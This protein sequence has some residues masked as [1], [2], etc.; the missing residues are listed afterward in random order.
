MGELRAI[1][2]I[3]AMSSVAAQM[4][5]IGPAPQL[6]WLPIASLR[7]DP[8]YQR[9]I[10]KQGQVNIGKIV[11]QFRWNR[12]AP[13]VVS[14]IAG[15]LYAVVDGQHRATAA[16]T[17][18][19]ETI[20]AQ[21]ILADVGEQA[22]AFAAIN[23]TVTRVHGQALHKAAVA[24]GDRMACRIEAVAAAAGVKV[25]AYPVAEL[26]QQPGETMAIGALREAIESYGDEVV[27]LALRSIRRDPNDVRG[28][29]TAII[30]RA[31]CSIVATMKAHD[32]SETEV[33]KFVASVLLI[34]EADKARIANRPKGKSIAAEMIDRLKAALVSWE[35]RP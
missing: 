26:N 24:A 34:R 17:L 4:A 6:T 32:A 19:L 25:L 33:S 28:G 13:I 10:T 3:P 18:G 2:P 23:G 27:V 8:L 16:A 1:E 7:I 35:R 12:F 5:S 20:P 21:I 22:E 30:I 11:A 15:G 9:P 14:P 31:V 29:L